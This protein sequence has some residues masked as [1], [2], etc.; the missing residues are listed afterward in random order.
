M[1]VSILH[2]WNSEGSKSL[3]LN[4]VLKKMF[5]LTLDLDIVLNLFYVSSE[6]N[7]ADQPFR[8][9]LKMIPC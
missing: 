4:N 8:E 3:D 1:L 2:A 6:N 5:Q 9:I 7:L